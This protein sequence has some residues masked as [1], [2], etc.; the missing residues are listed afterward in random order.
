MHQVLF[1]SALLISFLG[2]VVALLAPCCV[3]VMLPA[4]FATGFGRRTGIAAATG[5]FAAGVATLIVPIGLGASAL[6]GALPAHHLLIFSIG[7]AAMLAGG[8]AVLAGWKPM[9]PMPS[10]RSPSGHGYGAAYGLGLFSGIA[11]ACCAPVLAGVVV[12]TGSA[13]SFGAALAV[14]L[15]YVAGMVTPLAVLALVWE[16]RDWGSSRLLH[17]RRVRLGFGRLAREMPLGTAASG[18]VLLGMGVV[19]LVTAV[20]GPSMSSSGW[21]ETMTAFLQHVSSVTAG[22][23]SWLPGWAVL[24]VLAGLAAALA[25]LAVRARRRAAGTDNG[26][27]DGQAAG[28]PSPDAVTAETTQI[29]AAGVHASRPREGSQP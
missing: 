25:A 21:R 17:G 28:P 1:G 24:L 19:T 2:G 14:S 10:L 22:A 15:T 8:A 6:S 11:S 12:L 18:I 27:G 13:S 20:T 23:L 9:L 7:G 16:G 4:Y 3:S 5:V 29:T 26:P